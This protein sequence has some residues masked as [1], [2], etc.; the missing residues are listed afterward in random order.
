[1]KLSTF[2]PKGFVFKLDRESLK[3]SAL[4]DLEKFVRDMLVR[5]N[6][7]HWD[8]CCSVNGNGFPVRLNEAKTKLQYFDTTTKVWTDVP[9][10]ALV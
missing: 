7:P 2:L 8:N 4:F 3:N 9:A 10:A 1:M 5:N 6:V